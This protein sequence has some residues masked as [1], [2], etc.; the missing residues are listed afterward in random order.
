MWVG[1]HGD[2][3]LSL[4]INPEIATYDNTVRQYLEGFT[5]RKGAIKWR[6]SPAT[7][8]RRPSTKYRVLTAETTLAKYQSVPRFERRIAGFVR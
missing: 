4:L 6:M 3:C 7:D 8:A 5:T 1:Q 2:L